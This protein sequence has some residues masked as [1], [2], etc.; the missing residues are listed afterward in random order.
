MHNIAKKVQNLNFVAGTSYGVFLYTLTIKALQKISSN[1]FYR[2]HLDYT[3]LFNSI[4]IRHLSY[5]LS[6][7]KF[8]SLNSLKLKEKLFFLQTPLLCVDLWIIYVSFFFEWSVPLL[9]IAI[10]PTSKR[11]EQHLHFFKSMVF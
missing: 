10:S 1:F 11:V 2:D 4:S 5:V 8:S 6:E 7:T 3:G 9:K